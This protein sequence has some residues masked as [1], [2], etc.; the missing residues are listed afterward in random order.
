VI[1]GFDS[2][3]IMIFLFLFERIKGELVC[4]FFFFFFGGGG[5]VLRIE[6][7]LIFVFLKR[8]YNL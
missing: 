3:Q 8:M 7:N 1:L 5:W 4:F 6:G 2:G